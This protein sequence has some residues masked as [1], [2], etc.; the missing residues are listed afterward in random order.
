MFPPERR[1]K[2]LPLE[3]IRLI[4]LLI[5]RT[6]KSLSVVSLVCR[7]WRRVILHLLFEAV[8]ISDDDS[9]EFIVQ[10]LGLTDDTAQDPSKYKLSDCVRRLN[11][12]WRVDEQDIDLALVLRR[13]KNLEHISWE[14]P[15]A[16]KG[17]HEILGVLYQEPPGLRSLLLILAQDIK[18]SNPNQI[19][20]L[21][22]LQKLA[23]GFKEPAWEN[24]R[25]SPSQA[26]I[27]LIRGAR[28]IACLHLD[29][30]LT[31]SWGEPPWGAAELFSV[32]SSDHFP[33]LRSLWVITSNS[34]IINDFGGPEL[35]QFIENHN[36]LQELA[37]IP[38]MLDG[39]AT[40]TDSPITI[41]PRN[42]ER[43]LVAPAIRRFIGTTPS[44]NALL[45]SGVARQLEAL[46]FSL[47]PGER[48]EIGETKL[49]CLKR[50][51]LLA[52]RL[53]HWGSVGW[54]AT[55]GILGKLAPRTP[56]L[57]ELVVDVTSYQGE[58]FR[59]ENLPKL[60]R[61]LGQLP[62]L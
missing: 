11:V 5:P 62:D 23:I 38:T 28:N 22:N 4:L 21:T 36:Q 37:I 55:L 58:E 16:W 27:S 25:G 60:L 2:N 48:L 9:H 15:V 26:L 44:F 40:A 54:A 33:K 61:V 53:E 59:A 1:L 8:H 3:V 32:L 6:R 52:A 10:I 29:F 17:W 35:H 39:D 18:S 14:V 42:M 13:L 49:P 57:Q 30:Q 56:A 34:T 31:E 20:P 24:P 50:L 43:L 47:S 19:V 45:Q 51:Q 41:T 7:A 46:V 12:D